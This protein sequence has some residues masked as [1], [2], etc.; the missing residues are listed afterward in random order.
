MI[1]LVDMDDVLAD[2]EGEFI[3]RWKIKH[4]D[5]PYVAREN[6]TIFGLAD[7]YPPEYLRLV[8]G[9][10]TEKG[11]F[12][13]L[14]V[15]EGAIEGINK[16]KELGHEVFIC[17]API[18]SYQNC[19]LEKYEW[20]NNNLGKEWTM[21]II[22]TRDKTLVKGNILIDDNPQITGANEPEWEHVIYEQ[23]Y[24]RKVTN[25]RRMTW[26]KMIDL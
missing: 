6:R 18:K 19:V 12:L 16:F 8:K 9:I 26:M 13:N 1:I 2:F 25:K 11:F 24:N 4:P 20:V 17:T 14:P 10:Y 22:L 23:P 3:N 15:I 7:N 5:K 21:R